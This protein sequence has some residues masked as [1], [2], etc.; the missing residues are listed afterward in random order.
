MKLDGQ[1]DFGAARADP[2]EQIIVDRIYSAV[3]DQRLP[4]KTKLGEAALCETFGVGRMRV[5]RALLLLNSQG[6]VD[7]KSNRGAYVACPT[8][9]EAQEVFEARILIE[10]GIV[11][12][13]S[14]GISGEAVDR[15]RAH[16]AHE[17]EARNGGNGTDLIRLSGEFHVELADC[18]GN[19]VLRRVLRELV[20]RTSLIVAMFAQSRGSTCPADEHKAIIDAVAAGDAEKAA[21]TVGHHLA[22][23]RDAL[24]LNQPPVSM[25]DLAHI[26]KPR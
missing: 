8:P 16:I 18:H 21:T 17:D 9:D 14:N 2:D 19:A 13:L 15:L 11:R 24:D 1:H 23:I 22:H 20:T 4:P 25:P 6:I 3:M 12:D 5:R 26:L 10:T 7:L